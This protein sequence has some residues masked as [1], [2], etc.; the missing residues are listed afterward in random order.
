LARIGRA[1]AH[2]CPAAINASVNATSICD[3]ISLTTITGVGITAGPNVL[4]TVDAAGAGRGPAGATVA[5]APEASLRDGAPVDTT[6]TTRVV[7]IGRG[8]R[9]TGA[10]RADVSRA[11]VNDSAVPTACVGINGSPA[12]LA[13]CPASATVGI[14]GPI[15]G[16]VLHC[17]AGG[18]AATTP[19]RKHARA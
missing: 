4:A 17:D 8:I 6:R 15:C 11:D 10:S 9:P 5:G 1:Q 19:S 2:I 7:H 3:A 16:R 18:T 13:T 12:V 14:A